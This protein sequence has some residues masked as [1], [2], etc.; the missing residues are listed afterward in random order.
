MDTVAT[1]GVMIEANSPFMLIVYCET[2]L[3]PKFAGTQSTKTGG[4]V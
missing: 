2:E 1:V 3:S 4:Q